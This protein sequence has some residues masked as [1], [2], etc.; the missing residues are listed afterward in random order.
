MLK[1]ILHIAAARLGVEYLAALRPRRPVAAL[2]RM[3]GA[4]VDA[5]IAA[6]AAILRRLARALERAVGKHRAQAHK[7]AEFGMHK[8]RIAPYTAEA[9]KAGGFFMGISALIIPAVL[10]D[11]LRC[12]N[13]DVAV[14][15]ALQKQPRLKQH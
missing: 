13:G 1:F 3:G 11:A 10:I 2:Y 8:E 5:D 4:G 7:A 9:R 14:S 15:P 6:V 12:R